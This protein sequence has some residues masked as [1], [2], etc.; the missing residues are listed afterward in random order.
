VALPAEIESQLEFE[1]PHAGER[2]VYAT[3]TDDDSVAVIDAKSLGIHNVEAGDQPKFL[4]TLAG[5]DAAIVLNT[6]SGDATIIRTSDGKSTTKSV[7]VQAGVNAIRVAPDGKHAVVYFDSTHQGAGVSGSYQDISVL[8]LE[9]GSERS[10]GMT[11]GFRP[12]SVSFA[13]DGSKAFVVTEDGVSLLDFDE[14]DKQGGQISKT[15]ALGDDA[16]V[17]LDVSI[18]PDGKYALARREGSTELRLVDLSDGKVRL[19]DLGAVI[20][21]VATADAGVEQ[22]ATDDG[23]TD[24]QTAGSDETSGDDQSASDDSTDDVTA[25]V[26][27]DAGSTDTQT[28]SH[29]DASVATG[30]ISDSG[31]DA[32]VTE[33]DASANGGVQSAFFPQLLAPLMGTGGAMDPGGAASEPAVPATNPV[34][35]TVPQPTAPV[36]NPVPNP[37]PTMIQ[38]A[39][40]ATT[41]V[42]VAAPPSAVPTDVDLAPSGAFAVAVVRDLHVVVELDIP[43]A[44]TESTPP[45]VVRLPNDVVGSVEIAP[46]SQTALLYTTALATEER[47]F[48]LDIASAE[49]QAYRLPKGVAQVTIADDSKTAFIVHQK[50]E[51]DPNEPGLDPDMVL[52]RSYGYSVFDFES[53][54]S[55]LQTASSPVGPAVIVPDGSNL[56]ILFNDTTLGVREV[57]QVNLKSFIVA[58]IAL[59]SPP[60]SLGAV[61][62]SKRVF[63]GQ[64]H[65]D[66]RISF[67]DWETGQLESVTG[68]ELNSRIRE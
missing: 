20:G 58:H 23:A 61:P 53:G 64:E 34:M 1:L 54:F 40:P 67:I 37:A 56:F 42:P 48:T 39:A 8:F 25:T 18:T 21:D 13:S 41:P 45:K 57:H 31:I 30:K 17:S 49:T 10:V 3:N 24:D 43:G 35:T 2:Y 16:N 12:S 36:P 15:I 27:G 32:G 60:T 4:Q 14:I 62:G 46:N 66:G 6:G 28:A 59:G 63:V 51:G 50:L 29:A 38:T 9:Q 19:L 33:V 11:V 26:V 22:T 7:D 5:K 47:I 65:P 44:F 68:F 55:K 52:D